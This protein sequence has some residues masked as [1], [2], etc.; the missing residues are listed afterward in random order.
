[1]IQF[2][3]LSCF[4][5]S[6]ISSSISAQTTDYSQAIAQGELAAANNQY[7]QAIQ[8]FG[9]AINLQPSAPEAYL[10]QM[11]Y[12]IQKRDLSVFKRTIQQLEGLEYAL[13]L[14]IYLTYAQLAK[15]KQLYNDALSILS[16]A[17]LKFKKNRSIF[18]HR[19][20]IYQKL[21]N[22][23]EVLKNLNE[24]LALNPNDQYIIHLLAT[25]LLNIN[26][27]QS[28]N[29]FK[30]LLEQETYK[31]SALSS[32]GLLYF[33]AYKANPK[34]NRKDLVQALA[35]YNDYQQRHSKDLE[36]KNIIK[37]IHALL[38]S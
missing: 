15:K 32:L 18:L 22:N 34:A 28:I 31:S 29:Y 17:E 5:L 37:N 7:P 21:N 20:E 30:Q 14:D 38:D 8:Y 33:R 23:L 16:K 4:I 36:V 26:P 25:T 27:T 35:Y 11:E 19:V 10:K 3:F 9:Q 2:F 6:T 12:A 1:M 24:A 13:T